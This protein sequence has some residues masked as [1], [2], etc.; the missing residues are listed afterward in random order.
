MST[1]PGVSIN[2]IGLQDTYLLSD[3]HKDSL[4]TYDYRRHSNFSKFQRVTTITNPNTKA[5]WPFKESITVT[6]NPQ[7][8]GDLLSNF[9][10]KITLPALQAGNGSNYADQVG[11]HILKSIT[12]K[13]DEMEIETIYDDWCIIH[14]EIYLELSEKVTNR[15][16]VNRNLAYDSSS[17]LSNIFAEQVSELFIPIPFFFSRKF[18][19][20]EYSSNRPN[21][22]YFPL[23]AIHKQ[24]IEFNL[25]F[26]A[27]TFFTDNI[28]PISLQDF[29]IVTEE[30]TVDPLERMF[31]R[32]NKYL[33]V[34]DIVR[35]HPTAETEIGKRTVKTNLIPNIPVKCFH[36]FLRNKMFEDESVS[37]LPVN[38]V[39]PVNTIFFTEPSPLTTDLYF[40]NNRFNFSSYPDV[41]QL[42]SFFH[43]PMESAYFYIKGNRL[44]N[45]TDATYMYYKYLTPFHNR[46][47]R[48]N[49][50]V[51]TYSFSMHPA[52]V[53]PSGS[54]DF[55]QIASEKTNIE[56]TLADET[57]TDV[58]VLH[59]YYTGYQT[60]SFDDGFMTRAY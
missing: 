18:A 21:R 20:D 13:V 14:D 40:I 46:L 16:L 59:M 30:I 5:G 48:P 50:N 8:M 10:L 36:W 60:F 23:C 15:F 25:V 37:R 27:Q 7:T 33:F 52:N 58:Y 49:R 42:F 31:F 29:S 38:Y 2:A 22:P 55:S 1:G 11:R 45:I 4:F 57:I 17:H 34:T 3:D 9:Y 6:M 26:H 51:F 44:P 19:S 35:R 43:P 24:K 28:L 12:M 41:D 54:L 39:P 53:E 32:Q 56:V 47:S